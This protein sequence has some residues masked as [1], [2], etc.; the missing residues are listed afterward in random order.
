MK[1]ESKG[2]RQVRHIFEMMTIQRMTL[3]A[4]RWLG[5]A[6]GGF[7]HKGSRIREFAEVITPGRK[8]FPV[9]GA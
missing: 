8:M 1:S 5:R 4:V 2:A 7:A 9:F 3:C 6:R